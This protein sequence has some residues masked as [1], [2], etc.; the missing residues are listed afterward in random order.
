MNAPVR[1]EIHV[2]ATL[3]TSK[4]SPLH[5]MLLALEREDAA[6]DF[7]AIFNDPSILPYLNPNGPLDFGSLIANRY[8]HF[9]LGDHGGIAFIHTSGGIF[10]GYIGVLPSSRGPWCKL[11]AHA[12]LH[13]LFSTS[14]AVEVFVRCP[15]IWPATGALARSLGMSYELTR[16]NG[17]VT[18]R[19]MVPA[20]IYRL[21]LT[22]WIR[23][24]P[25][26]AER[27][28]WFLEK[29]RR[30]YARHGIESEP[31]DIDDQHA[32]HL[33]AFV[34]LIF[35]GRVSAAIA[36]FNKR[37]AIFSGYPEVEL[38]DDKVRVVLRVRNAILIF[39]DQEFYI[40]S[41]TVSEG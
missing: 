22:D 17:M 35:G 18:R 7:N 41:L 40:H 13:R 3:E 12:S 16:S 2:G 15:K 26:L 5:S 14:N 39:R 30:E 21:N 19:G 32:R 36:L 33:G 38:I 10:E 4:V 28:R 20:D 11:F 31:P 25:G 1:S 23:V 24:A 37:F 34:E 8:N 27:G 29:M 6:T 9:F